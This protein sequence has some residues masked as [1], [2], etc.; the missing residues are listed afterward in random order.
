MQLLNASARRTMGTG[1]N[2][3]DLSAWK[4]P[5]LAA[6]TLVVSGCGGTPVCLPMHDPIHPGHGQAVTYTLERISGPRPVIVQFRERIFAVDSRGRKSPEGSVT[7]RKT[8]FF[9]GACIRYTRTGGFPAHS[10]VSYRFVVRNW[11]GLWPWAEVAV[12]EVAFAT[13]PYR[14][15]APGALQDGNDPAGVLPAPVY[16]VADSAGAFDIVLI[17]DRDNEGAFKDAFL[18]SCR[19]MIRGAFLDEPCTRSFRRSFNFYINPL[20]G[21]ASPWVADSRPGQGSHATSQRPHVLPDNRENLSFAE[22]K[23]LMHRKELWDWAAAGRVYSTENGKYGTMLHEAGHALFGLA[24]EYSGGENEC[25]GAEFPNTWG[26]GVDANACAVARGKPHNS[27]LLIGEGPWW[28]LCA[29][30][31]QMFTSGKCRTAY[32]RPCQDRVEWEVREIRR[33]GT[34]SG[35]TLGM[36]SLPDHIPRAH[37]AFTFDIDGD[38]LVFQGGPGVVRPGGMPHYPGTVGPRRREAPG[39]PRRERELTVTYFNGAG[40]ELGAYVVEDPRVIRTCDLEDGHHGEIRVLTS[41]RVEVLVPADP[42]LAYLVLSRERMPPQRVPPNVK[43]R[44][45]APPPVGKIVAPP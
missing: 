28:K 34:P 33:R 31:C 22:A 38:K 39:R 40:L 19:G 36:P 6:L 37:R 30:Q 5:L 44:F 35:V 41:G 29:D 14:G 16:V 15:R 2:Q 26:N 3:L 23:V 20:S 25:Q 27:A 1:L 18:D 7:R 24:D 17:P 43:I 12:E 9:P 42:G 4:L 11:K 8:W 45:E 32:D 21:E 10:I 13:R